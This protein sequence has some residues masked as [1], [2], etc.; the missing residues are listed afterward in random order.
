MIYL[1]ISIILDIITSNI[2][3]TTYQNINYFFPMIL[4]SSIP[5][6]YS[7]IKNKKIFLIILIIL[8]LIYDLLYSDIFL[9]NTYYFIL[10]YLFL[11]VFYQNRKTNY[12]NIILISVLG[13][14]I[15]DIYVFLILILLDYSYFEIEYLYYKI[16]HSFILN[17]LY[18]IISIIIL[19][20]RI[21]SYKKHR[22]K[23]KKKT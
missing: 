12:F 18:V 14:I 19:K 13:F 3:T 23:V 21:F 8:G 11:H 22:R 20:S 17:F 16:F 5:I 9:I 10:Y 4:V 2:I 1:F 15:Y 7:L 6:T